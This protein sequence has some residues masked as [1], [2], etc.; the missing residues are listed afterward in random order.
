VWGEERICTSICVEAAAPFER[1]KRS[2]VAAEMVG[3]TWPTLLE[4][5]FPIALLNSVARQHGEISGWGRPVLRRA[6]RIT[7]PNEEEEE[8]GGGGSTAITERMGA[9]ERRSRPRRQCFPFF[10][11]FSVACLTRGDGEDFRTC[12][13]RRFYGRIER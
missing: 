12:R 10:F 8:R 1:R 2:V 3:A 7:A 5:Q 13:Y 6:T 9:G 4:Q 11:P